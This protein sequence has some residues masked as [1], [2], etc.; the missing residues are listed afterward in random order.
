[1]FRKNAPISS[2]S[3]TPITPQAGEIT[4]ATGVNAS[5]TGR[6]ALLIGPVSGL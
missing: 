1:M 2:T 3:T 5:S 6:N 4:I